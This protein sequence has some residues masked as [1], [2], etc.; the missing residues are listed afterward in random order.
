MQQ[1][2]FYF[3]LQKR[4]FTIESVFKHISNISPE[5]SKNLIFEP[6]HSY[7]VISDV[8]EKVF[9]DFIE[10][11]INDTIPNINL[12]NINEFINLSD[13]FKILGEIID[14]KKD[15]YGEYLIYIN[16]LRYCS[17]QKVNE[18]EENIAKKL[19][20]YIDK[21]GS[22]LM[23]IPIQ[24]LYNIFNHKNRQLTKH[25]EAYELINQSIL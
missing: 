1:Q 11:L 10:Y 13:E 21:Y 25:D 5:I 20:E 24:S 9:E 6:N 4:S 17:T 2:T 8:S 14:Q 7:Q 18:Y 23:K 15:E 12:D 22:T 3:I 16:G 19:D